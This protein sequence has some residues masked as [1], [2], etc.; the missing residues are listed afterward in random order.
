MELLKKLSELIDKGLET[1]DFEEFKRLSNNLLYIGFCQSRDK[2]MTE[3]VY[4]PSLNPEYP[5]YFY[6]KP[7]PNTDESIKDFF[8][9]CDADYS[10]FVDKLDKQ[11][12]KT[13]EELNELRKEAIKRLES[14]VLWV[15]ARWNKE[16]I[17]EITEYDDY[18]TLFETAL[19]IGYRVDHNPL[20]IIHECPALF[21]D[22]LSNKQI[23]PRHPFS[24]IPYSKLHKS[25]QGA[26]ELV[27]F[28]K[29]APNLSWRLT[30]KEA[31]EFAI[32][33]GYP[34]HLFSDLMSDNP[35]DNT[36]TEPLANTQTT[37]NELSENNKALKPKRTVPPSN[38]CKHSGLLI[39]PSRIDSWFPVIDDMTRA[40][41]SE[42]GVLPS[43]VLA[44]CRLCENPPT[45]Y[46]VS[47]G[48]D[49]GEACLIM[50]GAKPLSHSAFKGR[51]KRYTT[52]INKQ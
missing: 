50:Q 14:P 51:W 22:A 39:I 4:F 17:K 48:I 35:A 37:D 15:T 34:E 21:L 6:I 30:L 16:A 45:G 10:K 47:T 27:F 8:N 18:I 42:N 20:M 24:K 38:E 36:P 11:P 23:D 28:E 2:E 33:K 3:G 40:F 26:G 43:D 31:A 19:L 52:S 7:E 5:D 41:F 44:W 12:R 9:R 46:A 32:L 29:D 1:G 25:P 49:K 13:D